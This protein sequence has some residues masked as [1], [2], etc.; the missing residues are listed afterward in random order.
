MLTLLLLFFSITALFTPQQSIPDSLQKIVQLAEDDSVKAHVYY[1][2]SKHYY[3][4]D[5]DSA[6]FFANKSI[7]ISEKAG[8]KKN[9]ANSLNLLG[10]SNLIKSN[11]EAALQAHFEALKIRE[12]LMDSV[13][14]L[15]SN[16]NLG[17][18]YYRSRELDKAAKFYHDA[19]FFGLKTN[20]QRGLSLIYNNLGSYH[21]DSWNVNKNQEDFDAAM[22]Y[23]QKALGIKENLE[24]H[25]G[26]INT[27][28]QLSDLYEEIG[29]DDKSFELLQRSWE[30]TN[31]FND[32]ESKLAVLGK[33]TDYYFEKGQ[34]NKALDYANQQFEIAENSNSPYQISV[35]SEKVA[36]IAASIG[37]YSL[38]YKYLAIQ[39]ANEEILFNESRQKIRD[40]LTI[41][42]E[43]E[44]KELENQQ[45]LKDQEY[46]ALSL[47][48][49]NEMLM[50]IVIAV[51]VL[52]V[53]FWIQL[54]N[55]RKLK[56][57][58]K[59]L[60]EAY[61]LV[62]KQHIQIQEQSINL[63][64]TNQAL[65]VANNFR[66]KIFSVISHDLRAPFANI[67]STIS[68][69]NS[70]ILSMDEMEELMSMISKN[71]EAAFL[72]LENLLEW[73]RTQMESNEVHLHEI[74]LNK[75]IEENK[76]LFNVQA[77]RKKL[78]I[79]NH[80]PKSRYIISDKERLNFIIRNFL[81]N[82]IKFTPEGGK[83][84]V[85]YN[86]DNNGEILVKDSGIG[87]KPELVT[88]LF[89][90]QTLSTKG[91]GGERGAGIGLMLCSDFAESID[92]ELTVESTE[93]NGS[94][95]IIR[96]G[97]NKS[98]IKP[99]SNLQSQFTA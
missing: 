11:Y 59:K 22:D 98:G 36:K 4:F 66:D 7:E 91:T 43:T 87:I 52:V 76:Q 56:S 42:Y 51:L 8:L 81:L 85:A 37:N 68:L 24:D 75:L 94:T 92:A 54:Q 99:I 50:V 93:Y 41:Q 77:N 64:E 44:K 27:L 26:M 12:E 65:K 70:Q 21:L 63:H 9:H 15:E 40:E 55:H 97:E 89:K 82:A 32:I 71:N 13:G 57:T 72:M 67:Q 1:S 29:E 6:I 86:D 28:N 45:L 38:A 46:Y 74:N 10:V 48:R 3:A 73:A 31:K 80:V 62:N 96:L 34:T 58:H 16:L 47:K 33:L 88:K 30:I 79:I 95:F 69:W 25:R 14:L 19:L 23:L 49:K 60:A 78:E 90:N 35:A 20:N 2:L 61:D 53:L 18:I 83:I 5:Q 17:N 39:K 84:E